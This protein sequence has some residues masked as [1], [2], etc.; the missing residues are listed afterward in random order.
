MLIKKVYKTSKGTFWDLAEAEKKLNR[1]KDFGSRMGDP[2]E[3]EPVKES[4][5]LIDEG[6]IFQLT[7]VEVK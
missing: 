5:V 4:W 6:R 3:Y 2:A 7:E 1:V